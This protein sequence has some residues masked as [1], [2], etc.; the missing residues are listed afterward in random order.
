M[1]S[2]THAARNMHTYVCMYTHTHL[3]LAAV[4]LVFLET[5]ALEPGGGALPLFSSVVPSSSLPPLPPS[6]AAPSPSR[7]CMEA[8]SEALD[9]GIWR[10]REGRATWVRVGVAGRW[11]DRPREPQSFLYKNSAHLYKGNL[12]GGEGLWWSGV[13]V[14]KQGTGC[15]LVCASW[16]RCA[17]ACEV[18]T[19]T[20]VQV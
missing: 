7:F 17:T 10:G 15:K 13:C 12:H 2:D 14:G 11:R 3:S 18:M 16:M 5:S 8:V 20:G 1:S 4:E 9:K 6:S 19:I